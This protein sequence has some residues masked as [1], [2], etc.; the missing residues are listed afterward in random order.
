M[1]RCGRVASSWPASG[2]FVASWDLYVVSYTLTVEVRWMSAAPC[3]LQGAQS[4]QTSPPKIIMSAGMLPSY[5]VR[6]WLGSYDSS[7]LHCPIILPIPYWPVKFILESN[8]VKIAKEIF[9]NV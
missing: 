7:T 3:K 2:F 8:C 6:W 9:C 1:T 4:H 5:S